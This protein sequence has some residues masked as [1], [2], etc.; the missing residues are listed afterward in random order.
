MKERA[1]PDNEGAA[2]SLVSSAGNL[3]HTLTMVIVHY[4]EIDPLSPMVNS[5]VRNPQQYL[6]IVVDAVDELDKADWDACCTGFSKMC[7][8]A[9][10]NLRLI[11]TSRKEASIERIFANTWHLELDATGDNTQDVHRYIES[12]V[13]VYG[14]ENNFSDEMIMAII[15]ELTQR[16]DGMFLW[17]SLAWSFFIGG[18]DTWRKTVFQERISHLRRLPPGM[19]G[20][21]SRILAAIDPR[22]Y[23]ELLRALQW[24]VSAIRPMTLDE[25]AV[26]LA[27]RVRPQWRADIDVR[28]NLQAFFKRTCPHLIKIDRRGVVTFVHMSFK[29]FLLDVVE[30]DDG[31]TQVPNPFLINLREVHL[32]NGLDCLSYL[33]LR[34][35]SY[36]HLQTAM[37]H[38][39]FNYAYRNWLDH[40]TGR[41]DQA[42]EIWP[43]LKDTIDCNTGRFRWYDTTKMI[44]RLWDTGF[45]DLF[46]FFVRFGVNL[47]ICRYTGD[48]FVHS[49]APRVD[50]IPFQVLRDLELNI[51]GESQ[52]GQTLIQRCVV[53]YRDGIADSLD[54]IEISVSSESPCQNLPCQSKRHLD[55]LQ[56]MEETISKLLS[57]PKVDMSITDKFGYSPLGLAIRQGLDKLVSIFLGNASLNPRAKYMALHHAAKEGDFAV[58]KGILDRG[59][60]IS[61]KTKYGET[62]LHLA[63]S[64]GHRRILQLL[65]LEIPEHVLNAKDRYG[66]TVA[67]HSVTSGNE[68]LVLW[69]LQ[70]PNVNFGLR[71]G[72]GRRAVGFAA[73]YGTERMLKAILDN[74]PDDAH[75]LDSFLNSLFHMAVL[76]N[77][78][79][80][81][82]FLLGL[83]E[84]GCIACPKRNKWERAVLDITDD[85][86]M[87]QHLQRV[88]HSQDCLHQ[89]I[90]SPPSS[91]VSKEITDEREPGDEFALVLRE[92]KPDNESGS[93]T[94]SKTSKRKRRGS[95]TGRPDQ[96]GKKFGSIYAID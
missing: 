8:T 24:I 87:R 94:K 93:D 42:H 58:V 23:D 78:Y 44:F 29:D 45:S 22:I 60:D 25:L 51:N 77:N 85:T 46:G 95:E 26:A 63:A 11:V 82:I 34:D 13:T 4:L 83:Y 88:A 84:Q 59:V 49:V 6:H 55:W 35:F 5:S 72:H 18:V 89:S 96:L 56:S 54:L 69:L 9:G 80:N 36:D 62:A 30:Y 38:I 28:L 43:L 3:W 39:F 74:R 75:H 32:D 7:K 91:D 27:L 14:S 40:L 68:E 37:N 79:Q 65:A 57:F 86:E 81:L 70:Q 67:H 21:Y 12:V 1:G 33:G 48:H 31:S 19:D 73:A 10:N 47:N 2:R 90:G 17:A 66:W 20:L 61:A 50:Q 16:A 53:A 15:D 41:N 64:N 92:R 76:G 52:L 71:D